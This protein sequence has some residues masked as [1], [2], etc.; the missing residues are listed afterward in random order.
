MVADAERHRG[1]GRAAARRRSTPATSSTPPPTRWSAGWPSW[2]TSVPCTRRP[3]PRCWSPTP[4]RRSRRRRR[5]TG[6][7]SLTAELQQVYH[8]LGAARPEPGRR[9]SAIGA[10][11]ATDAQRADDDVIDA[12]FTAELTAHD[13]AATA[14][15]HDGDQPARSRRGT[16][17]ATAAARTAPTRP[18]SRDQTRG[19]RAGGPLA[20][21]AGRSSTTSASGT[22]G[23]LER[24]S[25]STSGPTWQR[26]AARRRQPRAGPRACRR[27]PGA[28]RRGRAGGPRPGARRPGPPRLPPLRRRRRAL[29]PGPPRGGR[30]RSPADAPPGTVVHGRPARLRTPTTS[31]APGRGRGARKGR[32]D[33]GTASDFYEVLGVPTRRAAEE[34]Q[35]AY[36]KLA[37]DLPP[38]RQQ[39]PGGRGAVQGDLRGLRRAVRPRHAAPLRRLRARLPPGA[40][41]RGPGDVG[42]ARAA[43]GQAPAP[44]RGRG[45]RGGEGVW[46]ATS[47]GADFDGH[48]P[49]RPVRRLFGRRGRP[50]TGGPIAGADQE[51]ELELSV[52]EAYPAAGADHAVRTRRAPDAGRHHPAR[53]DRRA[54]HPA[55]RPGRPGQRRRPPPATCTSSCAS[56]PIRA[57]GSTGRDIYVDLPLAPWEAALGASVAVDTPGGEA[58][59]RVPAGYVERPAAAAARPR[60]AQPAGQAR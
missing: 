39:G 59:V 47:G 32:L 51:A 9:P 54:A 50:R 41:R 43:P 45:R 4:A 7:R 53:G 44:S 38:R 23:T 31:A 24:V 33:G 10:G 57:T 36:R 26:V 52:E 42:R 17:R 15:P 25:A 5:S 35:R 55:G 3:A 56:R 28:D 30:R 34:I 60:A 1:R 58:K 20:P 11:G 46:V 40:R 18:P 2:A 8:G 12:E 16:G 37:R 13:R 29:R 19:R 14:S 27:R 6:S 22:P 48:R 49:R 21:R